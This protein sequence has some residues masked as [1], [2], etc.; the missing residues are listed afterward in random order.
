MFRAE[1]VADGLESV[2]PAEALSHADAWHWPPA[3]NRTAQLS[4]A[5]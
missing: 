2:V 5:S 4:C 3:G 1:G